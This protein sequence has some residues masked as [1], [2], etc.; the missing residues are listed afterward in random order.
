MHFVNKSKKNHKNVYYF[1]LRSK[2]SYLAKVE[3]RHS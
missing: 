1:V 3:Y 2:M